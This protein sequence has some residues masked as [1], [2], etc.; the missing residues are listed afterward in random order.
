MRNQIWM[1]TLNHAL[2]Q[3]GCQVNNQRATESQASS[4]VAVTGKQNDAFRHQEGLTGGGGGGGWQPGVCGPG[5]AGG[6]TYRRE[7]EAQRQGQPQSSSCRVAQVTA[8]APPISPRSS[9]DPSDS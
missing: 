1:M 9:T 4:V 7:E 3:G 8:R 6:G 5:Q 2:R